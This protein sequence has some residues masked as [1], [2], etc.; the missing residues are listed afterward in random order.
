VPFRFNGKINNVTFNVGPT[1]LTA[2]E[3]MKV[4]EAAARARD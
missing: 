1:Q 4:R 3:E 2:A